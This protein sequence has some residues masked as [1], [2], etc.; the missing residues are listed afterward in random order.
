MNYLR[1][2]MKTF[3]LACLTIVLGA[4]YYF[5]HT[6]SD[7]LLKAD[8][9]QPNEL[10]TTVGTKTSG[11]SANDPATRKV[12]LATTLEKKAK[13][14]DSHTALLAFTTPEKI[15]YD[16]GED[17]D[18]ATKEA[19]EKKTVGDRWK[20]EFD[21]TK[22][23]LTGKIPD[24]IHQKSIEAA[25]KVRELQLPAEQTVGGLSTRTL[26]TITTTVRGPNNY[27]GR[28]RALAFDVRNTQIVLAGGISSGIFRSTD[29]GATWANVTPSNE[30]HTVSTIAQDTRAGN[31][32]IWYYGTGE[33]SNGGSASGT[34]ASYYGNG[35]WKSTDNGLTWL[36]LPSTQSSLYV[37]GLYSFISKIVVDP[38]NG[39]ILAGTIGAV[40]RSADGGSTWAVV[41]PISDVANAGQPADIIYNNV[42]KTFYAS[43]Y[44]AGVYSSA[45]DGL[46]WKQIITSEQLRAGGV[47]RIVLSNVA[48]TPNILALFEMKTAVACNGGT[49]NAGLQLYDATAAM[50]TDHSSQI[51]ICAAGTTNPKV[52]GF[53]SGYNMCVTTKPDDAN[54]VFLGA[55][56]VYRLN[57][58]T[59][60]Y[61]YI[62]GDQGSANATNLHVDNHILLFEPGSNVTMWAGNDGGMRKTD[63]TG[64][65][66]PGPTGGYN[67]TDRNTGYI[68]YQ[69]YRTDISPVTGSNFLAGAAQDNAFTLH[70]TDATA[71]EILGGD[72]TCVGIISGTDFNT[73]NLI[74]STQNGNTVR[75][76]NGVANSISPGGS[77]QDFQTYF[78]LDADNTNY[79]YYPTNTKQLYRTHNAAAIADTLIGSVATG[80]EEITG[81]A[82]TFTGNVSTMAVTRNT[83][84]H[85][86]SASDAT[87]KMYIGTDDG[88][89]YRLNDPA[90][91]AVT[92]QPVKITPTGSK[93]YVSDV[94]VNPNNDKEIIVTYSNY[95]TPSV[96]HTKD[97]SVDAPVWENVEGPAG[98]AV[99]LA[100]ARSAMIVDA[101]SQVLYVVGTSTGLYGT[102]S[103]SGATTVWERI[104]P[105]EIGLS[106]STSMR[107]RPS[108]NKMVLGTHGNGMFMLSFPLMSTPVD[109]VVASDSKISV[110]PNP[111]STNAVNLDMNLNKETE[112]V[113]E[114]TDIAGRNRLTKKQKIAEGHSQIA[115]DV[116]SLESGLYLITARNPDS[117]AVVSNLRFVKQ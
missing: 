65:I 35:I 61:Q 111:S 92:A 70:P 73:Y 93:G 32:N 14:A 6:S 41:V 86:Y 28:T 19:S 26:P 3:L 25:R 43:I 82:A 116:S 9:K 59:G 39:V 75:S 37:G 108:D 71:K 50:W 91:A 8:N 103:L 69:F 76:E 89:V 23:P 88:N 68:T 104:A 30:I 97:A 58:A 40:S 52:L 81:V 24:G 90:F 2:E 102:T 42:S 112:L 85:N 77:K 29:G 53:Q 27:G 36:P 49:S 115:V 51:G 7:S 16:K 67:W 78:L 117:K 31:E 113:F 94:A 100:S 63:V 72:G 22:D 45:D 109:N 105:K 1:T 110:Y 4:S 96:W 10:R 12:S 44:G 66:T 34:G 15:G 57:L 38:H 107:L 99:E 74:L 55:T 46:T 33:G 106:P 20:Y 21:I 79:L 101:G 114:W 83:P 48:N 47:D 87:R 56:E 17:N 64:T 5:L 60:D 98:S 80:W 18:E 95:N 54:V 13:N 62:G 84:G 11:T